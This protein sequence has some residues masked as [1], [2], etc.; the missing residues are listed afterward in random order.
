MTTNNTSNP[1]SNFK[2]ETSGYRDYTRLLMAAEYSSVK[3]VIQPF[4]AYSPSPVLRIVDVNIIKPNQVVVVTFGN[5]KKEK[6]V[7]HKEDTFDLRKCLFI[8]IAKYLYKDTHTCEGIEYEAN[9]LMYLKEFNKIVDKA[10]KDH[11]N[12]LKMITKEKAAE[13][14]RKRVVANKKRKHEEYLKRRAEK[15]KDEF[16]SMFYSGIT[17]ALHDTI[18]DKL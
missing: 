14:E 9:Q 6:L 8:A 1:Y 11:K 13:E 5:G 18:V 2:F 17:D 4:A 16:I 7:C 12:K 15:R 10:L 3:N